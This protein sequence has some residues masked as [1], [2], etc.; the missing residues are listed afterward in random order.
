MGGDMFALIIGSMPWRGKGGDDRELINQIRRNDPEKFN[1]KEWHMVSDLAKD[2][3]R[4]CLESNPKTRQTA[5][6][7]LDH[8]WFRDGSGNQAN[9]PSLAVSI[10][11][12]LLSFI[13]I[14][15]RKNLLSLLKPLQSQL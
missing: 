8:A 6:Q 9:L 10:L 4:S 12:S 14:T 3:V 11:V 7:L 5:S 1:A 13:Y 15:P 2:F